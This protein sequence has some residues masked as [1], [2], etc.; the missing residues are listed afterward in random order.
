MR[1]IKQIDDDL[2]GDTIAW[3]LIVVLN[4]FSITWEIAGGGEGGIQ[5]DP[6]QLLK[7]S[8]LVII[9]DH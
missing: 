4:L 6:C 5:I 7:I 2:W 1:L 8:Q 9:N 3:T